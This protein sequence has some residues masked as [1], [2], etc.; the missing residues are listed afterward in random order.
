MAKERKKQPPKEKESK[1]LNIM[2]WIPV[3]AI[4]G[5]IIGF[6]I[7]WMTFAHFGGN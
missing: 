1:P 7:C 2:P 4:L 6:A 3:V 5:L